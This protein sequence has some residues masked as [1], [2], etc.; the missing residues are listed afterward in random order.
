[1][2]AEASYREANAMLERIGLGDDVVVRFNLGLTL[3]ARGKYDEALPVMRRVL[4]D[5][6]PTRRSGYLGV[7][8]CGLLPCH[9]AEGDWAAWD[10]HIELAERCLYDSAFV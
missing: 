1:E 3:I 5:L 6:L 8:Y 10:H 9:A 4:E 2:H 7:A